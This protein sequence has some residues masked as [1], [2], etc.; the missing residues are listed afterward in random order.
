MNLELFNKLMEEKPSQ[1]PP[2]WEAFLEICHTHMMKHGIKNP[3]VVELGAW[4]SRQKRFYEQLLG[5]RYTSIDIS[6]KRS[7]PDIHGNTHD[8]EILKALKKKLGKEPINIL[9][10]DASH[11][12]KNVKK[13]YEMYSPLCSDIIAFHD[14]ELGRYEN[15]GKREAWRF[16]DELRMK[17][18][19]GEG[20]YRDFTVLSIHHYRES[21]ND[22]QMGIGV[23]I[24]R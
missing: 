15:S 9:F 22:R 24:K 14:V 8:P 1:N 11:R 16:W 3:I 4:R 7:I 2:E 12:Y 18:Y 13:D 5:A 10:I 6:T 19:K 20:K 23:I 17:M 21:K